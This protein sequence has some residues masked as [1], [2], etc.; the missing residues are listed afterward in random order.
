MITAPRRSASSSE[1]ATNLYMFK[2]ALRASVSTGKEPECRDTAFSTIPT[3]D[4]DTLA[5][6]DS[7]GAGDCAGLKTMLELAS[8]NCDTDLVTALASLPAQIA[9]L[10]G[11]AAAGNSSVLTPE[12]LTALLGFEFPSDVTH[13]SRTLPQFVCKFRHLSAMACV[14]AVPGLP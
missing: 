11:G 5:L 6:L 3:I 2:A 12:V 4:E 1:V 13:V 8:M 9:A 7:F 14:S 10:A